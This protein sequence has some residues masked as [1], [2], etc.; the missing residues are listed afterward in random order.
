MKKIK[1][2]KNLST[3]DILNNLS[4]SKNV[5]N[6]KE[7]GHGTFATVYYFKLDKRSFVINTLLQKGEYVIKIYDTGRELEYED[8]KYLLLLSKYGLV[9]K[10]YYADSN[11]IIM[12]YIDGITL[13]KFHRLNNDLTLWREIKT[14][15]G[16]LYDVWYK[17]GFNHK[18]LHDENILIAK[19]HK[20]YLIDPY[21]KGWQK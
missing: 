21:E 7:I 5:L 4:S 17:L 10:I 12:K 18:D 14:R 13:N 6:L 2:P 16:E 11:T 9:P 19:N 15:I 20:V 1:N 8:Q 3:R